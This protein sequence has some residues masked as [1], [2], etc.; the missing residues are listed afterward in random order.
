MR[1]FSKRCGNKKYYA[2]LTL[3]L[4]LLLVPTMITLG[5][6]VKEQSVGMFRLEVKAEPAILLSG[7][8]F[9]AKIPYVTDLVFGY[10]E[11]YA[12]EIAGLSGTSV[13]AEGKGWAKLYRKD[14]TAY[15]LSNRP[16]LANPDCASMF[17]NCTSLQRITWGNFDTRL[18]T[19]MYGMFNGC[20]ALTDVGDLTGWNTANVTNMAGMF[21]KCSA[22]TAVDL[23]GWDTSN[24]TALNHL[25]AECS[26]LNKIVGLTGWD[27]G[28][29]TAMNSMFN[30]CRALTAVDLTGWD[31]SNV[32]AM[33]NLF[34]QCSWLGTVNLSGWDTSNVTNMDYMFYFCSML[35]TVD[36]TGWDTS[37][38]TTM[39]QLFYSGDSEVINIR[40][41]QSFEH[42]EKTAAAPICYCFVV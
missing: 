1:K 19:T 20:S 36:L 15:V 18:V 8:E 34:Y 14:K 21:N 4:V 30:Q 26:K 25:F 29:V 27:T 6:Y 23:T 3:L 7:A 16:I 22:L 28:K 37:N 31:T 9:N 10:T 35:S 12:E 40:V 39:R 32:T 38:V 5:K 24:V 13:S 11:D 17:K 41:R 2:L 33:N 42:S